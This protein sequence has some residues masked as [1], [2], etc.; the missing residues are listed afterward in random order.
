MRLL[1]SILI[2]FISSFAVASSN[3]VPTD[4]TTA[5]TPAMLNSVSAVR[6]LSVA[7]FYLI[8]QPI[9][10]YAEYGLK[11]LIVLGAVLVLGVLWIF[12]LRRQVNRRTTELKT[13]QRTLSNLMNSLPGMAFRFR[14]EGNW[15]LEFASNGAFDIFGPALDDII[16]NRHYPYTD[17]IHPE[18]RAFVENTVQAALSEKRPYKTIYRLIPPGKAEKWVWEQGTGIWSSS[19]KLTG[20]EGLI[21]DITERIKSEEKLAESERFARSTVDA[22]SANI[23]ILDEHGTILAVNQAWRRFAEENNAQMDAVC[24]GANYF[25]VCALCQSYDK[26]YAD[27]FLRGFHEVIGEIRET[28]TMEYPCHSPDEQRWFIGRITKFQGPGSSRVVV[29]HENITERKL[30]EEQIKTLSMAV[31]QS[32]AITIISDPRGRIEYVNKR[33]YE[34]SGFTPEEVIGKDSRIF[35]AE[36][37]NPGTQE[38]LLEALFKGEVWHGE[39]HNKRKDGSTFWCAASISPLRD[40][41]GNI[42]HQLGV[43]MDITEL[44]E[45]QKE[46][47]KLINELQSA[48]TNIKTLSGLLPICASCKKIRD[49][50]GYWNSLESFISSRSQAQFSHGLCPECAKKYF[51]EAIANNPE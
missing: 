4:A 47:E 5:H 43:Q 9:T 10:K 34:L 24:E 32:P 50:K 15:T 37:L 27:T 6:G 36:D 21:T 48:L 40:E 1:F 41:T 30:A 12:I 8:S 45:L 23:A 51:P 7:D 31:E 17:L 14:N 2:L 28:F 38:S 49:D 3:E 18:D 22:L 46:R 42:I 25:E 20:K 39:F 33:F 35:A 19:G 11:S 13:H 26:N 44:K 29:A 16:N